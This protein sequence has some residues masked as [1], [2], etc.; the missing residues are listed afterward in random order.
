VPPRKITALAGGVGA[1]K[2]LRGL[3]ALV[4]PELLTVIVNT[5]DDRSFFGLHVCPD[6][7]IV[8][9]TLAG[10]VREDTG[11][12]LAG[13]TFRTLSA[14]GR[15]G[16]DLWFALGDEDLATHI[17]RTERLKAGESLTRVTSE[18]AAAFGVEVRILPMSDDPAPTRIRRR[19]GHVTDFEEYLV[20]DGAPDD[21]AAVD[22][23]SAASARPAPG[24]IEA[25]READLLLICPSN[26]VVSIGTI[27]AMPAV[28]AE[29]R[30]RRDAIAISPILGGRPVKGPADRLLRAW[31]I[32]VSALG[33]AQV[34]REI[35]SGLVIDR[36]DAALI[37][38]IESLGIAT[39][40]VPTL[41]KDPA[42]AS[43]LARDVLAFHTRLAG[44]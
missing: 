9:Y 7:D 27:R 15:F 13:D 26:P 31:G 10:R 43:T 6:L 37:E 41:M 21:I 35:L 25:L 8:T 39:C 24:V 19:D 20:R 33:V 22:L 17:H 29:L 12:G 1:A 14:L 28:E 40:C 16:G 2:F 34:Y 23:S 30:T 42:T 36:A 4:A 11:W 18:I 5:G 38:P 32:E 3:A 44:A